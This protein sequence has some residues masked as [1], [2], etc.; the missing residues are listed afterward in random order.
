MNKKFF[1]RALSLVLALVLLTVSVCPAFAAEAQRP[2]KDCPLVYV[3][4]FMATD[5]FI[6]PS[7]PDSALAW[8][9]SVDSILN[10]VKTILPD[11]L[12]FVVT[13]NYDALADAAIPAVNKIFEPI[14]SAP[15]GSI[16]NGSGPRFEY[17]AAEDVKP[18]GRYSF[19]YDWRID[20]I[21]VAAQLNDFI[22]YITEAS[23][24]DQVTLEC[25]SYG[26]VI[27]NT[28]AKLYGC[29]KVRAF[30]FNSTAI[31]G[32]TYTGELMTGQ[33]VFNGDSLTEYLKSAFDYNEYEKLL[34]GLF[35]ILNGVGITDSLCDIVNDLLV[36]IGE[37]VSRESLAP[38]FGGWLSIWA[39]IPDEYIDDAYDFVFNDLYKNETIDRS[40]LRE[41][42]DSYNTRIRPYK[43]DTLR[44]IDNE[45]DLYVIARYGYSSLFMTPSW[46]NSS[47]NTI[48][49]K[50]ASY[51]ATVSDFDKT[52]T[53][54][55][56]EGVDP[57]FVSPNK[58]INA[59]TCMFPEQ[60]WFIRDLTHAVGPT[61]LDIMVETLLYSPSQ[62]TV[63]TYKQYPRYNLYIED[64][65]LIEPDT[66]QDTP[67]G[68]EA[69]FARVAAIL[70]SFS[71]YIKGFF[72]NI[73]NIFAFGA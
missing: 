14:V 28:Y 71:D 51:G 6:D 52:L 64:T 60:T 73:K 47:D 44:M 2:E 13:R 8:P 59:S 34:N 69:F 42:V 38:M 27:T 32:E 70:K 3:P 24:C 56:L 58:Q 33:I 41:K 37:R 50:Y 40:G 23:G 10:G 22:N 5:I 67:T 68:A 9:P 15:D 55:Q 35:A 62:A 26:G 1:G 61:S 4:G 66:L 18:D 45:C 11:I 19:R 31:F 30:C 49:L 7:D 53:D 72:R 17:P 39:M 21:E 29:S 25:H 48:D 65:S 20:P 57:R 63:D 46:R 36:H 16:Q 54:T 43:A 12:K